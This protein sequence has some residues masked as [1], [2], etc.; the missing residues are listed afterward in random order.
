M[1]AFTALDSYRSVQVTSGTQVQDVEVVTASTNPT[2]IQFTYAIPLS[3]WV[4]NDAD[5]TLTLMSEYLESLVSGHHVV[6]GS[7][8]QDFDTN[9]LLADYV[10]LVIEYNRDSIGLPPLHGTASV[11]IAGVVVWASGAAAQ[12]FGG[13]IPDPASLCDD[14]YA[15]LAALAAA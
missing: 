14:E 6:G 11:P 4:N 2:G 13:G 12:G 5:S 8:S 7:P 9:N 1:A 3:L 15:R 10:D